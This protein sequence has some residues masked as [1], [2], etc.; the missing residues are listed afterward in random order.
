MQRFIRR[1][2]VAVFLAGGST[3]FAQQPMPGPGG[4][5]PG[6]PMGGP[7]LGASF[8]LSHT[9]DL[10]LTDQQVVKLAAIARREAA[11]RRTLIASADSMRRTGAQMRRDSAGPNRQD[12]AM[13]TRMNQNR[14][15]SRTDLRD[16]IA[17]LTPDQQAQ[18]W[19]MISRRG[20]PR[21][22]F[23]RGQGRPGR[24]EGMRMREP[25][26]GRRPA[27]G[28]GVRGRAGGPPPNG[29]APRVRGRGNGAQPAGRPPVE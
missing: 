5:P 24:G 28:P 17:V 1:F 22:R 20:E 11:R 25:R 21:E 8:L 10:Q 19:T 27:D 3:L 2:A 18:A 26:G 4:P 29:L 9:G 16:A 12:Q 14:E 7:E 6:A 15:Q 13:I 23:T